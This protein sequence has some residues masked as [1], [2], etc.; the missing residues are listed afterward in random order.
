[1]VSTQTLTAT[2]TTTQTISRT[3]VR[4]TAILACP[5][6]LTLPTLPLFPSIFPY[7]RYMFMARSD[8]YVVEPNLRHLTAQM[9]HKV[10]HLVGRMP[11][12]QEASKS[13]DP[14]HGI[15]LSGAL[16][17]MIRPLTKK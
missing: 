14:A 2:T 17:A 13:P 1:M 11:K 15:I 7:R 3:M 6:R 5:V 10:P 12:G 16:M 8:V 4:T 9:D